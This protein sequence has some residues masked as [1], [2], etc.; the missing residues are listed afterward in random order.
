MTRLRA[1]LVGTGGWARTHEAA[2]R[3]CREVELVGIC[4]HRNVDALR[5][6]AQ[7]HGVTETALELGEL[8]ART[9]PDI[10][11]V[12]CN[13]HYRLE[14]VQAALLPCVRLI[15]LE[16]PMALTPADAYEIE[17]LCREHGKL[18][19]VNHQKKF[20]PAWREAKEAIASGSIGDLLFLR[21]TCQ[22]NLLEQGTHLVDMVLHFAGYRPVAWVMGQIDDL[23]G[24]G[25][26]SAS[27][28]DAA[29]ATLA[30]AD[31]LRAYLTFGA[32][33]HAVPGETNKWQHFAVEAYGTR[34]H[35]RVALNRGLEVTLYGQGTATSS[36]R[37]WDL[38]HVQ[39]EAE[40]LDAAARY[41]RN[42]EI[43]HLSDLPRSLVSFQVIMAIQAS[44]CERGRISL[45]R[46]FDDRLM[47]QLEE[48]RVEKAER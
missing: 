25:K 38:Y 40:H 21:A 4:G 46:R 14:A 34:G 1:V 18:L 9:Q 35:V 19:L 43:G 29:A 12:A 32:A 31:G 41:A 10:V 23:E 36:E 33:G 5:S 26:E 45:P 16:K 3:R 42:P 24:L 11:D 39:A 48:L 17:R 37:G 15:N 22:G 20:L 8:V 28:P 30:F 44:A 6:L 27:A 47:A 13:P 7:E 2:Y